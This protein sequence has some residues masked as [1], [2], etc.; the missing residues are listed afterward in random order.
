MNKQE[1]PGVKGHQNRTGNAA[2]KSQA[3]SV[4]EIQWVNTG[5]G[6]P[7]NAFHRH[8]R[9]PKVHTR[10]QIEHIRN[11]IL[12]FGFLDPIGIWGDKGLIVEGH[13]RLQALQELTEEGRIRIPDSGVPVLRLDHLSPEERDAYMLEHN[14]ATME[15]PWDDDVLGE[16]LSGLSETLDMEGLFGFGNGT[17]GEEDMDDII[18]PEPEGMK[19]E[20]QLVID[21]QSESDMQEKYDR[22]TEIGIQCRPM[23]G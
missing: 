8:A 9:N 11:S 3:A 4:K 7:L 1:N 20:Y 5:C 15:T 22:L 17:D 6:L 18:P 19:M 21:C 2:S 16:L 10:E 14:Q 13:G 23:L 12:T